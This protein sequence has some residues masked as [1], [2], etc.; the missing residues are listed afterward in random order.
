[1]DKGGRGVP[2]PH[3]GRAVK[4]EQLTARPLP[5]S[6]PLLPRQAAEWDDTS[7]MCLWRITQAADE[8]AASHQVLPHHS[9]SNT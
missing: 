4:T 2:W 7:M 1:M 9:A 8:A 5:E 6:C 3:T